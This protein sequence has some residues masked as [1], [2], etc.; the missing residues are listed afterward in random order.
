MIPEL[1]TLIAALSLRF[2]AGGRQPA[3]NDAT[4]KQPQT[5]SA[6]QATAPIQPACADGRTIPP[7][8]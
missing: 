3:A 1:V 6:P 4:A 2:G 8:C 5:T 7:T